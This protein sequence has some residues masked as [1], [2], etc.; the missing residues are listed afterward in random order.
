MPDLALSIVAI[1]VVAAVASWS[2]WL[3]FRGR[4]AER[5]HLQYCL[6]LQKV[7][8]PKELEASAEQMFPKE[9]AEPKKEP[10]DPMADVEPDMLGLT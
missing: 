6:A 9:P 7:A 5:A 4:D 3:A 10:F 8:H 1:V 2:A